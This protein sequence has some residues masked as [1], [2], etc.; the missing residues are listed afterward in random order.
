MP[1]PPATITPVRK[2][3]SYIDNA[4]RYLILR[5]I[6]YPG[7]HRPPHGYDN[8][9]GMQVAETNDKVME[10][11]KKELQK[12]PSIEVKD[13]FEK[14][15]TAHPE[16]RDLDLRQFNARYPL[17]IKRRK[18]GKRGGR[19]SPTRRRR[20]TRRAQEQERR[21]AVRSTFLSFAT[22]LTAAED[23]QDLV[24]VLAGVDRYVDDVLK[25]AGRG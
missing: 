12:T 23:K 16:V 13:L 18:S 25:A 3:F 8:S 1:L 11:V 22:D 10:F 21:E 24:K 2:C 7:T 6:K 14:T 9:R 17:Q 15:K 19:K 4:S 5:R 20:G